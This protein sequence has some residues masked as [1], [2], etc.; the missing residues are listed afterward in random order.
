MPQLRPS[1]TDIGQ[2]FKRS[3]AFSWTHA[4][5]KETYFA[6]RPLVSKYWS[7]TCH[8]PQQNRHMSSKGAARGVYVWHTVHYR[9]CSQ[10]ALKRFTPDA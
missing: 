8:W 10:S 7:P 5:L 3:C 1:V 4:A 6:L 2:Y 9:Q